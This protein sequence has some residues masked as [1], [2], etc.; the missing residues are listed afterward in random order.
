[1][2]G[3]DRQVLDQTTKPSDPSRLLE[4]AVLW[5]EPEQTSEGRYSIVDWE[6]GTVLRGSRLSIDC[7]PMP[8]PSIA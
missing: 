3:I 5:G 2:K 6:R 1:M 8:R 4:C 7:S